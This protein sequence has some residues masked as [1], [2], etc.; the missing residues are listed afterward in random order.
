MTLQSQSLLRLDQEK[1]SVSEDW[2]CRSW[3]RAGPWASKGHPAGCSDSFPT[4]VVAPSCFY[5]TGLLN[6]VTLLSET[7]PSLGRGSMLPLWA[8]WA[9]LSGLRS[10]G[11]AWCGDSVGQGLRPGCEHRVTW[12][13]PFLSL[14]PVSNERVVLEDFFLFLFFFGKRF[15]FKLWK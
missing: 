14:A 9:W 11:G 6:Q 2:A 12:E 13:S 7:L 4:L 15:M 10:W 1:A 8:C 3:M 5:L